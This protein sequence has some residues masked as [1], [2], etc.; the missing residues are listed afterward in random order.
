MS[1]NTLIMEFMHRGLRLRAQCQESGGHFIHATRLS[2]LHSTF[3]I[4]TR[5]NTFK[6][7]GVSLHEIFSLQEPSL[8]W[9]LL[10]NE[11]LK[12]FHIMWQQVSLNI[13][14]IRDLK[15]KDII[16]GNHEERITWLHHIPPLLKIAKKL[17]SQLLKW[18]TPFNSSDEWCKMK[19]KLLYSDTVKFRTLGNLEDLPRDSFWNMVR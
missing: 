3:F 8:K 6:A 4:I 11:K 2:W 9:V 12:Q 14:V 10:Q 15:N 1:K 17:K 19:C 16:L 7:S 5:K 18:A 13:M